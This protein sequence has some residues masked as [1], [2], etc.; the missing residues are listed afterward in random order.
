MG[1][2]CVNNLCNDTSFAMQRTPMSNV[3]TS[4]PQRHAREHAMSQWMGPMRGEGRGGGVG[5][6][7]QMSDVVD[8]KLFTEGVGE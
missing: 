2:M 1:G 7:H 3:P 5:R 8:A 4:A 6:T